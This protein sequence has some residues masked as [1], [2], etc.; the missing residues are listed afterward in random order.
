[1][2]HPSVSPSVWSK[3]EHLVSNRFPGDADTNAAGPGT[4]P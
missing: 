4:L 1:M 2:C 3:A